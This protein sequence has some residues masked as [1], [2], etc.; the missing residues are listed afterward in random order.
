VLEYAARRYYSCLVKVCFEMKEW[1]VP[2]EWTESGR[3]FQIVSAAV[4]KECEPN[5]RTCRRLE[6]EDDVRSREGQ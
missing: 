6:E 5:I 1:N 3:E 4:W 2:D